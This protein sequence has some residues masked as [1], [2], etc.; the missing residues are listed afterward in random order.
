MSDF[1]LGGID[2]NSHSLTSPHRVLESINFLEVIDDLFLHQH[3]AHPTRHMFTGSE[4]G[5][6][7]LIFT[8]E[9]PS[10]SNLTTKPLLMGSDHNIRTFD[11][12]LSYFKKRS[13]FIYAYNRTKDDIVN[14]FLTNR[15]TIFVLTDQ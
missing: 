7:D 2:W 8:N 10:V 9:M 15:L 11:Y 3:V 14:N 13:K 4:G 1:N 12:R 6:L 5:I